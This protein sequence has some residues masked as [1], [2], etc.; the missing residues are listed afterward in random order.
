MKNATFAS[1]WGAEPQAEVPVLPSTTILTH[2]L[3]EDISRRVDI[4]VNAYA[5]PR[6]TKDLSRTNVVY[7]TTTRTRL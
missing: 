4:A 6:A 5:A 3:N 2:M 1:A 7:Y